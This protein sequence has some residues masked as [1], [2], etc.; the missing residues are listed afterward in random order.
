MA[1]SLSGII[2]HSNETQHNYYTKKYGW[3]HKQMKLKT[4]HKRLYCVKEV[5]VGAC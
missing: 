5:C 2:L 4:R 3:S 1:C